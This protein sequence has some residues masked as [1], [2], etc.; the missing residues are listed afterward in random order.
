M[1]Q[2]LPDGVLLA[3][4][5]DDF[6][7]STDAMEV[8]ARAGLRTILFTR[9][10]EQQDLDRFS[11]YQ[12][13]GVAGTARAQGPD[14]MAQNL[15]ET[16]AALA[17]LK[18]K[19]L[20]YKVCSTFDSSPETGSIGRAAELGAQAVPAGWLPA[21]V[22]AP[23]LGRWQVF[24]NLFATAAGVQ[25][26]IDRH[27][28]MSRHPVTP[29]KEADLRQHIALQ[30]SLPVMGIDLGD[31]MRGQTAERIAE[32]KAKGAITFIDVAEEASQ[33]E[34]GRMIWE[35][36][37]ETVFSPASSGL[38]YALVAHWRAAGMIPGEPPGFETHKP[39]DRLLVVSGSCSPVT[40]DQI[41]RAEA[42]GFVSIRLDVC[43]VARP[44]Q[45]EAEVARVLAEIETAFET[46][47]AALV[48][49]AKTVD[50]PDYEAL[51]RMAKDEGIPLSH[52]QDAIGKA[53]G[54]LALKAVPQFRLSRLVV[55]GGDTSGRVL[56]ALPVTALELKHPL[57]PGAPIC[58][59]HVDDPVFEG[60]EVVLKGGQLGSPDLFLRALDP[61]AREASAGVQ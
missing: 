32:A 14:W 33:A 12:V 36:S 6:T 16:F 19:V 17:S 20:Q 61:D 13:I 28:T 49:A 46:H 8:T 53:L 40:A 18:P 47:R 52:A 4:Y 59:C 24:G 48:F 1:T 11:D 37:D 21:I 55:A 30:T 51:S 27:P 56:E 38:Q 9:R 29:M 60:L 10:P 26:R 23:Q 44:D 22:G 50:D 25:Y 43:R 15:P 41:A 54:A 7:G 39:V 45:A 3:F 58:L 2:A 57:S 31:M 34:A 5:G 42:A 35:N